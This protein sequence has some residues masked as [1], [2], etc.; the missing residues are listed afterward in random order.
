MARLAP[1]TVFAFAC[2]GC[3]KQREAPDG[4]E[5]VGFHGDVAQVEGDPMSL[6]DGN[7]QTWYACSNRC[8]GPAVR[9]ILGIPERNHDKAN[10]APSQ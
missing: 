2:D 3:G 6:N 1:R 5:P 4:M 7:F 10:D 9:K 8:I